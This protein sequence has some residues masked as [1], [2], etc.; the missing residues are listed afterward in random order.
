MY[1]KKNINS[2]IISE[3]YTTFVDIKLK[4]H[5]KRS[6]NFYVNYKDTR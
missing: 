4:E 3:L 1:H 5:L 2:L 6:K